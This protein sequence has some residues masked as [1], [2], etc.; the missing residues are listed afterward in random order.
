MKEI[1][2]KYEFDV[3][4]DGKTI[5]VLLCGGEEYSFTSMEDLGKIL[6]IR[7]YRKKILVIREY[8]LE[9]LH[10][11]LDPSRFRLEVIHRCPRRILNLKQVAY[12][13]TRRDRNT[14]RLREGI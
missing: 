2:G 8:G 12:M 13:I 5:K 1:I 7:P 11:T 9:L 10:I 4:P 3:M 6:A 14:E